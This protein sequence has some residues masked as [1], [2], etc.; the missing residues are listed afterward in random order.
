MS[1]P[2]QL[3]GFFKRGSQ[4]TIPFTRKNPDLT[5]VDMTGLVTRI[6]FRVGSVN[7]VVKLTLTVGAGITIADPTKGRM[8]LNITR[9]Q[10]AL[11]A[12]SDKVYFDVEQTNPLD[13][14]YEWHSLTYW[15]K[16]EEQVTRND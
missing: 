1:N 13:T 14:D 11:F 2:V 7:G 16:V 4:W 6:M 15:F 8:I 9:N 10:S 3:S 12:A 5:A